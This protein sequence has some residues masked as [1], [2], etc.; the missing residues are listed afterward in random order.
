MTRSQLKKA[1]LLLTGLAIGGNLFAQSQDTTKTMST[2]YVQPFSSGSAFRTWSVGF[3]GGVLTPYSIFSIKNQDFHSPHEKIG[4][5]GFIKDQILPSFGLQLNFM[6]GNVA[7]A[8]TPA[9]EANG[10][11][12]SFNTDINYSVDLAANFTL[13]NINWRHNKS[14]IQPYLTLGGGVIGYS[15]VVNDN[16]TVTR[17]QRTHDFYLPVGAGF[18]I[19]L[20]KGVNLDLGYQVNFVNADDFDGIVGGS[21]N[22]RFS[23]GHVGLEF[24]LGSRSKPQLA[25]HNPVSSMRT[26][27]L[28]DEQRLQLQ[29]DRQRAENERLKSDLSATNAKVDKLTVDTDG[30]GV[31]D[32]FDK[33]PN[34]P[35]GTAVDGSGCPLPVKKPDVKVYVTQEDKKVVNEAVKNLEFDFGKS[36]IREHSF[37]SL[38]KLAQL[39]VSKGFNLKLAG[40]TDNVGSEA[41][42]LK[43]SRE[44][45]EAVKTYLAQQGADASKIQAEG[46]GKA[47]PI[48]TNKTEKGRQ[49]NRRVEFSMF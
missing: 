44:R 1:S 46:Y 39:L 13:A 6:K 2:D 25:T 45:A 42:N 49:I 22:D 7:G 28:M 17:Q 37:E 40:Y 47:N 48:A 38:N 21:T 35:A 27:Y 15:A 10:T 34:T 36:T 20:A 14:G 3:E 41:A 23:Y 26:E 16:G 31:P 30:D 19:D 43:L 4:Y 9:N 32:I 18:K 24:A 11:Y 12:T 8:V 29:V 33:C 5:G